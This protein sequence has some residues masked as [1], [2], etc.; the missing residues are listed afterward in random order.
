[1]KQLPLNIALSMLLLA[2][3]FFVANQGL[4]DVDA[5]TTKTPAIV[6][7]GINAGRLQVHGY[8]FRAG[9]L[10]TLEVRQKSEGHAVTGKD[11]WV[12]AQGF[13]SAELDLVPIQNQ[14]ASVEGMSGFNWN[15]WIVLATTS[16]DSISIPIGASKSTN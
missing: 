10:L 15:D 3:V 5:S 14:T 7:D 2:A 4:S 13:F 8:G 16:T 11:V 6:V 9:S 1:M 12:D